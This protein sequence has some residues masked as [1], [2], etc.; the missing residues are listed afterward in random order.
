[1]Q[2]EASTVEE[3]A[4]EEVKRE[5]SVQP[6]TPLARLLVRYILG[7]GVGIGVGLA[8]F[9]GRLDVPG[10]NALASLIP[11]ALQSTAFPVSAFLMG[12]IAVWIQ[13][14]AGE[15]PT[16]LWLRRSFKKTLWTLIGGGV[17]FLILNTLVVVPVTVP[18]ANTEASFL[19]G[20][21]RPPTDGCQGLSASSCIT[22]LSFNPSRIAD[23]WGDRQLQF[24]GLSLLLAYFITTGAFGSMIGLVLL[25]DRLPAKQSERPTRSA[26]R[27]TRRSRR[28]AAG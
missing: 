10:F 6:P 27:T 22:R 19:V 13:W 2:T 16:R 21:D 24:A 15:K 26:G 3:N 8:P 5:P 11:D 25:R 18:A 20:F 28:A 17:V 12:T 7:F 1:M 23:H 9:L 4:A 14:Q